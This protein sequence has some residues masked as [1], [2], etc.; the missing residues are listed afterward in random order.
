MRLEGLERPLRDA[1][2]Q[3]R[4]AHARDTRRIVQGN[5]HEQTLVRVEAVHRPR[6]YQR[7]RVHDFSAST[8]SLKRIA[9]VSSSVSRRER[10]PHSGVAGA[11]WK[12]SRGV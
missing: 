8:L 6:A 10:D 5:L 4:R 1:A 9:T 3:E 12:G 2:A 7:A 11:T